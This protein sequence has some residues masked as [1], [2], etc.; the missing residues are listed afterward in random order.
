MD[1]GDLLTGILVL[2]VGGILG[3]IGTYLVKPPLDAWLEK[4]R[5]AREVREA[6]RRKEEESA[7]QL[8]LADQYALDYRDKLVRELRNLRILDMVR[9]LDLERTYVRVRIQEAQPMRYADAEEMAS[10]AQGDPNLLLELSQ[11]KLAEDKAESLLPEEALSRYRHMVVLGDPGA[12]K[13]PCSSTCAC[14]QPRPGWV[15]SQISRCSSRSIA[16][17]KRIKI[18]CWTS[19]STM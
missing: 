14:S 12:A 13:P 19:L 8:Q 15:V 9:P 11:D 2:I 17:P 6:A 18:A 7:K 1:F 10:L 16:L 3:G 4:R 5:K